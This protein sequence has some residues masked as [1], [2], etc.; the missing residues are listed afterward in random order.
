MWCP[1]PLPEGEQHRRKLRSDKYKPPAGRLLEFYELGSSVE[2]DEETSDE[3]GGRDV[4]TGPDAGG[5]AKPRHRTRSA[6]GKQSA[7]AVAAAVSTVKASEKKKKRKRKATSPLAVV[8]PTI[9][10]P[11]SR[12]VESEGEEEEEE[13]EEEKEKD[14]AIE[15]LPITEDRP[16]RRSES[17]AEAAG[18]GG[19]DIGGCPPTR[20]GGAASC[21]NNVG[22]DACS[23]WASAVQAQVS[24]PDPCE[25]KVLK[26]QSFSLAVGFLC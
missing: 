14:E 21:C 3:A 23:D 22:K 25:V 10:T 11:L 26:T 17:P 6:A 7:S 16:T 24:H 13:E 5:T 1:A 4:G 19:E 20:F 9:P 12:E 2:A 8:T 18:A 15:E